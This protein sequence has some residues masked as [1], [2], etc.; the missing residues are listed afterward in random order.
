[1]LNC[2]HT[3]LSPTPSIEEEER[4][5]ARQSTAENLHRVEINSIALAGALLHRNSR[6]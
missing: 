3:S 4:A 5:K 6:K 1:M 2:I